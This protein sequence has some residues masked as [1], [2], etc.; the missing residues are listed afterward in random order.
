M[1]DFEKELLESA[2]EAQAIA[3]GKTQ[4]ARVYEPRLTDIKAL[5][6]RMDLTQKAFAIKFG[7]KLSAL[8][9]WEQGRRAPDRSARILLAV[10]EHN[11]GAVHEALEAA[12]VVRA[13]A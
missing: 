4:P 13:T 10:I 2:A 3:R 7:F 5:R 11:P 8:R 6:E 1:K 12:S 9:E